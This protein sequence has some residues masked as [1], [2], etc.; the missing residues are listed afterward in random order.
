MNYFAFVFA[1]S[2]D[3]IESIS[4]R[5][6]GAY[7]LATYEIYDESPPQIPTKS[8]ILFIAKSI[9]RNEVK[10]AAEAVCNIYN[11]WCLN[12]EIDIPTNVRFQRRY[13]WT[14]TERSCTIHEKGFVYIYRQWQN[15]DSLNDESFYVGMSVV[16]KNSRESSHISETITAT[17]KNRQLSNSKHTKI[18]K[19]L[20]NRRLI[21]NNGVKSICNY[22]STKHNLVNRIAEGITQIAALAVENFLIFHYYGV[23][24]LSNGTKGN[25]ALDKTGMYFL[26]RP[27]VVSDKNNSKWINIIREFIRIDGEL[28]QTARFDLQ[29]IALS[30]GTNFGQELI[31]ASMGR[32]IPDA[33]PSNTGAD[34]EWSWKF[35]LGKGPQ[36]IRFQLKF[37]AAHAAVAINLR[38]YDRDKWQVFRDEIKKIWLDPHLANPGKDVYFKPFGIPGRKVTIDTWF[39]YDDLNETAIIPVGYPPL[40]SLNSNTQ[41]ILTLPQAIT[42]LTAL[43]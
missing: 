29:L 22:D 17:N 13:E 40:I 8:S 21:V 4:A 27:R 10:E 12:Q 19:W 20:K 36:W 38:P 39:S 2:N 15:Q 11:S 43:F 30:D 42:R 24:N 31:A 18:L 28:Q 14:T 5:N 9:N 34:V 25:S 26:S 7:S 37:S 33:P 6:V 16:G 35:D 23:F 1:Q 3:A 32:L 41:L